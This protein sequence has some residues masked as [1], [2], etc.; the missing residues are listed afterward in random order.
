MV[1]VFG[2]LVATWAAFGAK[3]SPIERCVASVTA[4]VMMA[5]PWYASH[6]HFLLERLSH[7][8]LVASLE[9]GRSSSDVSNGIETLRMMV[10]AGEL[11]LVFGFGVALW[12]RKASLFPAARVLGATVGGVLTVVFLPSL[13]KQKR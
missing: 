4:I 1:M 13:D 7:E 11:L 2:L 12:V 9:V 10:P 6:F 3:R 8:T 5:G